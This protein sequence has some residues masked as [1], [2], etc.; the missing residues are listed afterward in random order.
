MGNVSLTIACGPY[1]RMEGI[2]SGAVQ[3]EGIDPTYVAIE[4]PVEIFARMIK[5]NAFDVSE[6]SLTTFMSARSR[7]DFPF[8]GIPVFPSRVFRHGFIFVNSRAGIKKPQDLGGR[9]IG[10][11]GYRQT[12]S[13]WIRGILKDEYDVDFS[14]VRWVDGGGSTPS[15]K[16][17]PGVQ[18]ERVGGMPALSEM[19]AQGKIDAFMGASAPLSF[20]KNPDVARLFPNYREV[21]REY[22]QRTGI[23]PIMHTMVVREKLYQEKPWIAESLFKAFSESKRLAL[24]AMRF[25]GAMRYML[26][27][28]YDDVDEIDRLFGRDPYPYGVEPNR[29]NLETLARYLLAEAFVERPIDVNAIFAP[30]AWKH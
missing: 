28:L 19:L 30:I 15:E 26:P 5:Q 21:E 4:S 2:R 20:G 8:V 6:M 9:R 13:V 25:S 23:F 10:V 24:R 27:W 18:V 11:Q 7:N 16:P 17:F 29:R 3:I 1:D 14:G 22:F 12:A